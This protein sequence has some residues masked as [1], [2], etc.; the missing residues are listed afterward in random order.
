M[1]QMLLPSLLLRE[2][3]KAGRSQKSS[4]SSLFFSSGDNNCEAHPPKLTKYQNSDEP[5]A[6]VRGGPFLLSHYLFRSSPY[7]TYFQFSI[8]IILEGH[9]SNKVSKERYNLKKSY[10]NIIV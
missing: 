7:G 4:S 9:S 8:I 2:R 6:R 5:K 3:E 10:V 1:D